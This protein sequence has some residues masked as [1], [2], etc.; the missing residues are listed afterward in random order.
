MVQDRRSCSHRVTH[1]ALQ[2]KQQGRLCSIFQMLCDRQKFSA[3]TY[4]EKR[5]TISVK[6]P[7]ESMLAQLVN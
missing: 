4:N 6:S 3:S 5:A 1:R 7:P 2:L